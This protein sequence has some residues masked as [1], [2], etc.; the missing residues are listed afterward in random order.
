MQVI[1]SDRMSIH[2]LGGNVAAIFQLSIINYSA[3]T[4]VTKFTIMF[5]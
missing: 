1:N 3:C 2:T 4:N 5:L